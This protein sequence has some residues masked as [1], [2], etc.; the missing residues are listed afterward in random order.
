MRSRYAHTTFLAGAAL[1]VAAAGCAGSG[2]T[3]AGGGA[4]GKPLVLQLETEDD[5]SVSGAPE[6]AKA[7]ERL[8]GGSMRIAFVQAGRGAQVDFERGVIEDV[9]EGRAQ[10]G[11]VGVRVWDTLG[12]TSFQALVAPFLVDSQELQRR[13]LESPLAVRM[14]DGVEAAGVVGVAVLPGPLRRP[15]GVSRALAGP[16][17]YRGATIGIRPG[18]V[19]QAAFRALGAAPKGYVPGALAGFDGAELDATTIAYNDLERR[20]LTANVVLWPKPYSIVMNR[21]ASAAL[22]PAQRELLRR[23]G[24][25]AAVPELRQ[26]ERAEAT[27]L[28]EM[29]RRG[30]PSFVT[31]SASELAA[32]RSAVRPVYRRLERDA[33]TKELIAAIAEL[34]A[35]EPAAPKLACVG[36]DSTSAKARADALAGR[37]E[38]TWTRDKLIAA[39][40][41]PRDAEAMSGHHTAQFAGGRF[42]FQGDPGSGNSA[43]GTYEIE[44]DVIR[45]VFETGIAV[46]HG[47][48]YEL[49]WNVYRGLLT[50]AAVPRREAL[51]AFLTVPYTRV[52]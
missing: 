12:A 13:V 19:A 47:R 7:V 35:E 16:E 2:A 15:F 8:S 30:R 11:I 29:C 5:L 27:S 20:T 52:H 41:E 38:T 31:A 49:K 46:Q 36:T 44:G 4:E 33:L 22:T 48:P 24:R 17:D 3:K 40:I 21:T 18:G 9:R 45:L 23:A 32:L 14:L 34:R 39:G 6:F 42:R 37:W 26:V 28:S 1:L 43:R 51:Q 10:L 25:E 50:F